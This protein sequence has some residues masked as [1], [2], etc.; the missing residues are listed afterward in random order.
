MYDADIAKKDEEMKMV[1]DNSAQR[2]K[3]RDS[4]YSKIT[5][6]EDELSKAKVTIQGQEEKIKVVDRRLKTK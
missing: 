5:E 3:E 6:K 1:K 2:L 4:L